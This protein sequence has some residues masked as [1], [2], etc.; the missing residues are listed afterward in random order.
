MI[1]QCKRYSGPGGDGGNGGAGAGG[2]VMLEAPVVN[3]YGTI[4]LL[5]GGGSAV[6]GGS[7]KTVQRTWGIDDR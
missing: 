7:V 2:G 3:A 6:N 1:V 5:G 4:R